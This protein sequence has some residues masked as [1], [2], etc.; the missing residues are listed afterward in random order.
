MT[1]EIQNNFLAS[2]PA[3]QRNRVV[4]GIVLVGLGLFF[5]AA[6]FIQVQLRGV[7]IL[8]VL[9]LTFILWGL[10]TRRAGLLVP[11]GILG[12]IGLGAYLTTGPFA[13]AADPAK[14]GVFLLAFG[15]GWALIPVTALIIGRMR[16]W[17][18][19]PGAILAAIGGLLLSGATGLQLLEWAGRL[20][21][22]VLVFVGLGILV[23]RGQK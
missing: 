3:R 12:G 18:L 19:L 22:L 21:P 10:L 4:G 14:G 9:A 15:A 17:P 6:Q 11:G 20:W 13:E 23:R 5:L 1:S 16:L 8:P 7:L 2:M